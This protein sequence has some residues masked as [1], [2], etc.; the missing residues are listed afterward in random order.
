MLSSDL[1]LPSACSGK[2]DPRSGC[3]IGVHGCEWPC[4]HPTTS[5]ASFLGHPDQLF[6]HYDPFLGRSNEIFFPLRGM[7]MA[8]E[9]S[10]WNVGMLDPVG[11]ATAEK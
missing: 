10:G 4:G 3:S 8:I 5:L 9:I 1:L 6:L 7:A 2:K 11:C